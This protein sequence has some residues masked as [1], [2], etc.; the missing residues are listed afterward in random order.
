[1]VM[2]KKVI[3]IKPKSFQKGKEVFVTLG[4]ELIEFKFTPTEL[5]EMKKEIEDSK[6]RFVVKS[7]NRTTKTITVHAPKENKK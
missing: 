1:M 7:I 2:E 4:G 5:A 3:K 6:Y